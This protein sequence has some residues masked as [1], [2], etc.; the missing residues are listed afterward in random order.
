M[1]SH[2]YIFDCFDNDGGSKCAMCLEYLIADN[3]NIKSMSFDELKAL[4]DELG[5]NTNNFKNADSEN[6]MRMT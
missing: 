6:V 4:M 1:V 2:P 5:I 3:D